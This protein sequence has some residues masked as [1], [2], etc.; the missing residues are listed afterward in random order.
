MVWRPTVCGRGSPA[1]AGNVT[2]RP[3]EGGNGAERFSADFVA[4]HAGSIADNPRVAGATKTEIE[5]TPLTVL[6]RLSC[7]EFSGSSFTT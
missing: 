7:E 1:H 3:I 6:A 5:V 4:T 2:R